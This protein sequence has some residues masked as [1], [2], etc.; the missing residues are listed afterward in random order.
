MSHGE[1]GTTPIVVASE[2]GHLKTLQ[3]LLA[4]RTSVDFRK[5]RLILDAVCAIVTLTITAD[6][7]NKHEKLKG[8]TK[9]RFRASLGINNAANWKLSGPSS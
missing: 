7:K 3:A 8:N 2:Q 1:N 5:A 6:Y 4:A 9:M